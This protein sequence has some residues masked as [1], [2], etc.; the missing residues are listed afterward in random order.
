MSKPVDVCLY[1]PPKRPANEADCH[2]IKWSTLIAREQYVAVRDLADRV[3]RAVAAACPDVKDVEG[4]LSLLWKNEGRVLFVK[5]LP[6]DRVQFAFG[7]DLLPMQTVADNNNIEKLFSGLGTFVSAVKDSDRRLTP[8]EARSPKDTETVSQA[9]EEARLVVQ[10][11]ERGIATVVQ[12]WEKSL[13]ET[14]THRGLERRWVEVGDRVVVKGGR[15]RIF[16]LDEWQAFF[17]PEWLDD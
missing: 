5:V 15:T 4:G 11:D 17:P 13:L 1:F 8:S 10:Q 7:A 12:V 6:D 9:P 2:S 3:Y 16:T 14:R